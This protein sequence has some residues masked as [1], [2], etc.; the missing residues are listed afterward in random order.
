MD[1]TH[2]GRDDPGEVNDTTAGAATTTDPSKNGAPAVNGGAGSAGASLV[3]FSDVVRA[4]H[5]WDA[6]TKSNG[7][8]RA[9]APPTD[10]DRN[11]FATKFDQFEQRERVS[12][13]AAY[14]CRRAESAVAL[15]AK[16]RVNDSKLRYWIRRLQGRDVPEYRL[17][18]ET[19]W[20]TSDYRSLA[21]LLHDC[22]VLAIKASWGLET[23]HHA[24]LMQWLMAVEAH[25][26][27]FIE[28]EQ[29]RPTKPGDESEAVNRRDAFY[30]RTQRELNRIETYYQQAGE[31]RARLN[32]VEGMLTT[33]LAFFVLISLAIAGALQLFGLLDLHSAGVRRFYAAIAAGAVGAT[34]SVLM[35]MA[36]DNFTIDHELGAGGVRLLG[37][38]RPLIGAVSGAVIALLL[39][40]PLLPI[41]RADKEIKVYVVAA[42]LAGFSERWTRVILNG[43]MRT[44]APQDDEPPDQPHQPTSPASEPD[45]KTAPA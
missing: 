39:Q 30:E 29:R 14:W 40:T 42:F 21:D 24:V 25:I 32:F 27:G 41:D 12:V 33:G 6:L 8:T 37:S 4:H 16:K 44:I 31:K 3:S 43:A 38:F 10:D 28:S 20:V 22:D 34:I 17:Y 35:R 26:L 18:R 23:I 11:E 13:V 15:A 36:R 19:D 9:A 5:R 2:Y 45:P 1:E 7:G